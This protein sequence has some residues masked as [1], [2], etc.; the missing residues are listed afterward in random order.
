MARFYTVKIGPTLYLTSDGTSTGLP[1]K[2]TV[3]GWDKILNPVAGNSVRANTGKAIRQSIVR[4]VGEPVII[5]VESWITKTLWDSLVAL[6]DDANENDT[7]LTIIATGQTGSFTKTCKPS[8]G[9]PYTA[10][11]F[12][13]TRIFQPVFTFET[14]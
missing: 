1:V 5:S 11:R 13:G 14:V 2:L 3:T 8:L 7:T 10:Q 9:V 6:I 4:P 12:R